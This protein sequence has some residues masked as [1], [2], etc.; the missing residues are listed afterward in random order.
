MET[1]MSGGHFNYDQYRIAQMVEE[2]DSLIQNNDKPDEYGYKREY[3]PETLKRFQEAADTLKA[4]QAMVQRVDWL[5]C[6][7]DGEDSFHERWK[8][9]V[10]PLLPAVKKLFE[11]PVKKVKKPRYGL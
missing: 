5:V 11:E 10:G 7:D 3:T 9:E 1:Q 4:A 2:I 8:Q 6:G